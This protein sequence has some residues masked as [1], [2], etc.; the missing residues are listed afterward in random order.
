MHAR[1][2]DGSIEAGVDNSGAYSL[3]QRS[4]TGKN[5]R[6]VERKVFKMK[7]LRA[8]GIVHLKLIP[9]KEMSADM[10]TKALDDETFHRHRASVMNLAADPHHSE[11]SKLR[12]AQTAELDR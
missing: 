3:C 12:S 6:H 4:T 9:T 7:E 11:R 10:L 2:R 1:S 8:S 5:S